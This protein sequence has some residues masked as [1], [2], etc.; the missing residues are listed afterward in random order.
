MTTKTKRTEAK[1]NAKIMLIANE[2]INEIASSLDKYKYVFVLLSFYTSFD[3]KAKNR[4]KYKL[5]TYEDIAQECGVSLAT[6]RDVSKC[7]PTT[8]E[9]VRSNQLVDDI[10]EGRYLIPKIRKEL[11]KITI[12]ETVLDYFLLLAKLEK[13]R[14]I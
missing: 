4:I 3:T 10:V 2:K 6:V 13:Q 9:I 12:S 14:D 1:K 5:F 11:E 8:E 7:S